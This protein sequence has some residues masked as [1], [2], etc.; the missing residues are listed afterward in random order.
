MATLW[1]VSEDPVL[2]GTLA[3]HLR[4][5]GEVWIG[6]AD[7]GD[8]KESPPPDLVVLVSHETDGGDPLENWLEFLLHVPHP[9]R[10]AP[11]ILFLDTVSGHPSSESLAARVDD[12]PFQ[13]LHWPL[14]PEELCESVEAL[15]IPAGSRPSLRQRAQR[16]W[17]SRRI[18][19]LYA[20]IDLPAL[21]QA[22]DPRNSAAPVLL[23]GEAGT[24]RGLIARYIHN[25]AEPEREN[26]VVV[27][28]P[29]LKPGQVEARLLEISTG[30]RVTLLLQDLDR[31]GAE[32]QNEIAHVLGQSGALALDALRWIASATNTRRWPAALRSLSWL[33]VELPPLRRRSDIDDLAKDLV[34]IAAEQWRRDLVL[35]ADAAALV[36]DYS[37]PGNLRELQNVLD[38][39]VSACSGSELS[40][41]DLTIGVD[42]PTQVEPNEPAPPSAPATEAP[43][44]PP[45]Q[46]VAEPKVAVPMAAEPV[47]SA[48]PQPIHTPPPAPAG[49][50]TSI[51]ELLSPL[52]HE[53]RE[54]LLALRT[55]ASLLEQRPDD[56]TLRKEL[57]S[58]LEKDLS[59]LETT[60]QRFEHFAGM[61][62][63]AAE[64][65]DLGILIRDELDRYQ[66]ELRT[67]SLV[68]L[69]EIQD[70]G[71]PALA[72]EAQL[73]FALRA[74]LDRAI[75]MIPD[76]GDLYLGSLYHPAKGQHPAHHRILLRFHSPEDTLVV[77]DDLPG[78]SLPLEILLARDVIQRM[79]GH[80]VVDS[81]GAQDNLILIDL[82]AVT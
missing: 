71:P 10:A 8:W 16:D 24:E 12:R 39:S 11:P 59:L 32:L 46:A 31:A 3:Y 76:G 66:A 51:N 38:A 53:V 50:T 15:L 1:I 68:V 4:P 78:P 25:L 44:R 54:P 74:L 20:G 5:L 17:V 13:A 63:P 69:R 43:P 72:D 77:P 33:R 56:E 67:R 55:C 2:P 21:R 70:D 34:Q 6:R 62:P 42:V 30:Q 45:M 52:A 41:A 60:L 14:D 19:A 48:A 57:E 64:V 65:V 81:S 29:T 79:N 47:P 9:R 36:R 26:F 61:K 7:R 27:A 28:A 80:I 58:L 49:S 75:R 40:A 73:R 22:I 35:G 37:W 18:A 82:P 23:I